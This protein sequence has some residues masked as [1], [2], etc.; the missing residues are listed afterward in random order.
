VYIIA[1]KSAR[2][3]W[4]ACLKA[5]DSYILQVGDLVTSPYKGDGVVVSVKKDKVKI[6][7]GEEF[8]KALLDGRPSPFAK[9]EWV[10]RPE[11][12]MFDTFY[13]PAGFTWVDVEG[14]EYKLKEEAGVIEAEITRG[15]GSLSFGH[16]Y[17][18]NPDN[19]YGSF[20]QEQINIF[21]EAHR[22][23]RESLGF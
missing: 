17:D 10:T 20:T 4:R 12:L 21:R 11:E 8:T 9:V 2:D 18:G 7:H 14:Y 19:R 13:L 16:D 3:A 1:A 22:K 5:F 6:Q 23:T 15:E